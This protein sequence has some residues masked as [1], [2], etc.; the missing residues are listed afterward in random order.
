[1]SRPILALLLLGC[2]S[3]PSLSLAQEPPTTSVPEPEDVS[4]DIGTLQAQ[5]AQVEAERQRLAEQLETGTDAE[6]LERLQEQNREL[7]DA[8]AQTDMQADAL[9]EAQRQE[10]FMIGGATVL[11]SLVIGF[12]LANMGRRGKRNEWLN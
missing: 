2:L 4:T 12:L 11:A 7:L 6:L 9:L 10:W 1:M 8:R 5:L 3:S